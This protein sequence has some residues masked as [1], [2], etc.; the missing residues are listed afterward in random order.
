MPRSLV[1]LAAA[2]LALATPAL[3]KPASWST[4]KG[5]AGTVCADGSPFH[6]HVRRGAKDK[7]VIFFNGGGACWSAE[8]CNPKAER[9]VYLSSMAMPSNDPNGK[10][11]IFSAERAENPFA[12]WTMVVVPYCTGDAHI[13]SRRVTYDLGGTRFAIEHKGYN[14]TQAALRWT[15]KNY[16]APK[17]VFVTGSSAGA[18]AAPFY[19]GAVANRYPK[20]RVT[21]LG[22]AAGAYRAAAIPGI[23]KSWGVEDISP[24]WMRALNGRP[25]N[26][27]TFFKIN[28]AA[29]PR[30]AQAQYN[31]AA[32]DVQ[33]MFL[34][35]LGESESVEPLM[36]A[37]L[38]E[39]H[40][41]IPTFRTYLAPG[42]SHTILRS[43]GF[44]ETRVE[45]EPLSK[46]VEDFA[47]G[48]P[49]ENVDCAKAPTGCALPVGP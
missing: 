44:Y 47:A 39:L 46:W 40:D 41:E 3:A 17:S 24:K 48:R 16:A 45:G 36:R 35:L 10:D 31:A 30:V 49:V 6:F 7:V 13:G 15:F 29:F 9:P 33:G 1:V 11:G 43:S 21:M 12:T 5:G 42:T 32:D 25:L 14:N 34:K 22:D 27:E 38:T 19:V 23:F 4:V 26:I 18:I 20:A 37:N 2:A 28:A 8:T